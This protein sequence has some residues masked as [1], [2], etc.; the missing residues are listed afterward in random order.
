MFASFYN[1]KLRGM[2]EKLKLLFHE[3]NTMRRQG[4]IMCFLE[5]LVSLVLII[6]VFHYT[7]Q[8]TAKTD[9]FSTKSIPSPSLVWQRIDYQV[10]PPPRMGSS[11]ILNP[12]NRIGFLFGGSNSTPGEL[13]DLWLTD[14][15]SWM[16]YQTPHAP[17]ARS[18]ASM[19]YDEA[20]RVAVLFG[21]MRGKTLLADT[22]LFN[23]VDWIQQDPTTS[24]SPRQNAS[25]A[26]DA[27]RNQIVLFGGLADT[28]GKFL[29]TMNDMWVWDGKNWQQ[30]FPLGLPPARW[31]ANLVYDRA[32]Q[33]L[34]LFG[35]GI[36]GSF[37]ED[38]WL[39]DGAAWAEQYPIH[40]PPGHTNFGMAYDQ[41]RQELILFGGQTS[42]D[43]DGA[44]TWAWNVG[45]WNQ[46]QTS[47]TSPH[48]MAYGAQLI[49]LP[50]LQTEILFND[51]GLKPIMS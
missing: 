22:W 40:H 44:E 21:G 7:F 35:G 5:I 46:L 13:N 24:P 27:A 39:W 11:L 49:Y 33:S 19:A 8:A 37:R 14:G 28:G 1:E 26:Y 34:L 2:A 31:G 18:N 15:Y 30:Q 3:V 47:L 20:Q 43:N 42:V 51:C 9:L 50:N 6:L 23:G 25:M 36:D 32:Y 4:K 17:G 48:G 38:T 29:E 12:I 10:L 16:Q 41:S 45:D